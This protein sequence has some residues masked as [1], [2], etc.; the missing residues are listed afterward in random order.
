MGMNEFPWK[1]ED[2]DEIDSSTEGELS[3]DD[4]ESA[5]ESAHRSKEVF[6]QVKIIN[7]LRENEMFRFTVDD[8]V[9]GADLPEV[10]RRGS[11]RSILSVLER[12]GI[13]D[14]KDECWGFNAEDA[15]LARFSVS[16]VGWSGITERYPSAAE[17]EELAEIT[18]SPALGEDY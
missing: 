6:I 12:E 5:Y 14:R 9:D 17:D 16:V 3:E 1:S 18:E 10:T 13:V 11:I 2:E 4:I 8:I 7:F 15:D